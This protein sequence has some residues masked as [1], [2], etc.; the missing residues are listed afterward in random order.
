ME[1]FSHQSPC[2]EEG[3]ILLLNT[4]S[5]SAGSQVFIHGIALGMGNELTST[6]PPQKLRRKEHPCTPTRE[7]QRL[8]GV[9]PGR[10]QQDLEV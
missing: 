2:L 7:G 8:W 3:P 1:F 9:R 10:G 6:P 4:V 5:T